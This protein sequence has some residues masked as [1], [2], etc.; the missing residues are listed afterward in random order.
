[1][2]VKAFNN[3]IHRDTICFVLK[4]G[5]VGFSMFSYQCSDGSTVLS[6]LVSTHISVETPISH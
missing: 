5:P 3:T 6:R 1:M 4:H 2:F